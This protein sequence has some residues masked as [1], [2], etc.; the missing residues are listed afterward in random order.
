MK[1]SRPI[2]RPMRTVALAAVVAAACGATLAPAQDDPVAEKREEHQKKLDRIERGVEAGREREEAL[3]KEIEGLKKDRARLNERLIDIAA[4]VQESETAVSATE[5]RLQEIGQRQDE[6]RISLDSRRGLLIELLAALERMGRQPPPAVLVSPEDALGAVRS[7]MLLGA[8]LPGVRVETE[9][10]VSDLEELN[11][12]K[13]DAAGER[14]RLVSRTDELRSQ[15]EELAALTEAKRESIA[16]S[17]D[18]LAA[19]RQR[20]KELAEEAE[21]VQELISRLDKEIEIARGKTGRADRQLTA[22][23]AREAMG[24]MARLAP[25]I[26]FAQT[27][28][29]LPRPVSGPVVREFGQ[30]DEYGDVARGINIATRS[31]AQVV[32]PADG[33]V[34]FA[35][36][37]RSYGE[38]LIVDAGGGYHLLLAGMNKIGVEV[39]QFVLAGEPV[40]AMGELRLASAEE[41]SVGRKQP[42]LYVEFRKDG[43]SI[44]PGPWWSDGG[45]GV[46]G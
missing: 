8:V 11:R 23:E 12:L 36:P 42:V 13:D 33:H 46:G 4:K 5:E 22:E 29:L 25:A 28:G 17:E 26:P 10:L 3:A 2:A 16:E 35:G 37:F 38:L 45:T 27:V 7:A 41:S 31:A 30:A 44:D 32:S 20:V 24:N 40:G 34:V 18:A 6:V 21:G 43:R 15:R 1:L 39:G 9:A 14:T 19:T